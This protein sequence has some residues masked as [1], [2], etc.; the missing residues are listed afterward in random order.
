MISVLAFVKP[1][2]FHLSLNAVVLCELLPQVS[3]K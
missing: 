2:V 3:V 1:V